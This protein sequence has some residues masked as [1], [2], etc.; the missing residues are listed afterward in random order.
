MPCVTVRLDD[1]P[2]G[3]RLVVGT[4]VRRIR[5]RLDSIL[6]LQNRERRLELVVAVLYTLG[7]TCR[8]QIHADEKTVCRWGHA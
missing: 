5:K 2:V 6:D 4:L 7:G 8:R 1:M 3:R